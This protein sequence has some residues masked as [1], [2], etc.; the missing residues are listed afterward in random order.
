MLE[1]TEISS[2]DYLLKRAKG[3][4]TL[5]LDFSVVRKGVDNY[6]RDVELSPTFVFKV[7]ELV[8]DQVKRVVSGSKLI[9]PNSHV[10]TEFRACYTDLMR[11]TL[12]RNKID[13]KP[14]QIRILQFAVVKFI[15]EKTRSELDKYGAQLDEVHSQQQSVGSRALLETQ[16]RVL[17]YRKHKDAFQFRINRLILRQCQREE[18]NHLKAL[19]E[20]ILGEELSEA[21]D[22][23]Y[24]PM[25]YTLSPSEPVLLLEY[26]SVWPNNGMG[27]SALN[28][29][30]ESLLSIL[31]P[32][33]LSHVWDASEKSVNATVRRFCARFVPM[34]QAPL[35]SIMKE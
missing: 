25:L 5:V 29:A 15:L 12:H 2:I 20:Q 35:S 19:R 22:I 18:N 33:Q 11:V 4:D 31:F 7:A 1:D 34:Y 13:L 9:S 10:M 30:L 3:P 16:A 26:Y 8:S 24:N 14:D 6:R 28:S 27:F 17:W 21:T 23:M 32:S